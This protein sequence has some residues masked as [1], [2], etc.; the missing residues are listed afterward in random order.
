MHEREPRVCRDIEECPDMPLTPERLGCP[1]R[2]ASVR[3]A[4]A[5]ALHTVACCIARP[6]EKHDEFD[7]VLNHRV[8]QQLCVVALC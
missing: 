7:R 4:I 8:N 2:G 1:I 5:N 3:E 6:P